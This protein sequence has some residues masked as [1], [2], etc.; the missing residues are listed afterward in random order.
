M[1]KVKS[2]S[3][4]AVPFDSS[5]IRL[6]IMADIK[7]IRL[8]WVNGYTDIEIRKALN[9]DFR[10]WKLRLRLMRRVSP[11]EDVLST[12]KRYYHEHLKTVSKLQSRLAQLSKI[13]KKASKEVVRHVE[14]GKGKNKTTVPVVV[15]PRDLGL[16]ASV[17]NS[18]AAIDKDILKAE[19]E[20]IAI[21]QRLGIIESVSANPFEG[22]MLTT[23]AVNL[24]A[25]WE[26]RKKRLQED[27][28]K[29]IDITPKEKIMD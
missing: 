25:A 26:L 3:K 22:E 12:Y 9:L 27:K 13:R 2:K 18:M 21:Q 10:A 28:K 1:Q 17:I 16:S 7:R 4:P 8:L 24:L 14:K 23:T 5:T 11:D 29:E 19:S 15:R 20:L 6:K